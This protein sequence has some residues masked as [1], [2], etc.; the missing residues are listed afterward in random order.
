MSFK[1]GLA[2]NAAHFGYATE[3][4]FVGAGLEFASVSYGLKYTTRETLDYEE[5][6]ETTFSHTNNVSGMLFL[7]QV[8]AKY[9]FGGSTEGT[10][11]TGVRPYVW[12]SAFYSI[13]SVSMTSDTTHDTAFARQANDLLTGNIGGTLALG[14]EYAFSKN[15][16]ISGEFGVRML[17]GSTRSDYHVYRGTET[18][19]NTLGLGVA[20][21]AL[22][23]NYYF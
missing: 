17:F 16:G 6:K 5:P 23:V 12:A 4:L 11:G 15:F 10:E 22:G 1:P 7:P 21:T 9:Y 13:S 19:D 20:Y 3:N 8:A 2:V 18:M 14:A